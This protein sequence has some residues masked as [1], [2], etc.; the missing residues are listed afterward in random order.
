MKPFLLSHYVV[1]K[2]D[3]ARVCETPKQ[4][5]AP[6]NIYSLFK[7]TFAAQGYDE[8]KEHL[9]VFFFNASLKVI[10]FSLVS[11]G[12]VNETVFHCREILRPVIVAGAYAFAVVHNHPSGNPDPSEADRRATIRLA[13]AAGLMQIKFLDHVVSGEPS[14]GRTGYFS[15]REAGLI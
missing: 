7:E 6:A 1:T 8:N 3:S 13:E 4:Y 11:M 9:I 12:S 2:T 14:P 15:F 10:G 5:T